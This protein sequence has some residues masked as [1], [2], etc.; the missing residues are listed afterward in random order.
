MLNWS[1]FNIGKQTTL[2]FDQSLGGAAKSS[3]IAFNKVND[4]SGIPSQILGQIQAPGQVYVI[5]AN[6]II[7]GGSAQINVNTLVASAL[8]INDNQVSRG[9]LNNPDGE[10]LFS[11][12]PNGTLAPL[13]DPQPGN[14]EVQ[15]GAQISTPTTTDH[16]GGR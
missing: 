8:S 15:A 4:P 11:S 5:N 14:V 3:W 13:S 16:V 12:G 10:F 9:L 6:G 7:F 2:T 1:S